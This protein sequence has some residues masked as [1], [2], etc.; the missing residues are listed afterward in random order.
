MKNLI[1]LALLALAVVARADSSLTIPAG[2]PFKMEVKVAGGTAPFTYEWYKND[3]KIAGANASTYTIAAASATDAGVYR[4]IVMNSAGQTQ[5]DRATAIIGPP[6]VI[7][8]P[9]SGATITITVIVSTVN[10]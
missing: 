3:V 9:P 6:P 7:V 2:K 4:A 8:T 10:P 1:L 5:T